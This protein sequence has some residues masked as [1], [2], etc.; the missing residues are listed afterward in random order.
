MALTATL[1][2][3]PLPDIITYDW[4]I[5]HDACPDAEIFKE[6]YPEGTKLT[7]EVVDKL[8]EEK[9]DLDFLIGAAYLI[10]EEGLQERLHKKTSRA[11]KNYEETT[12]SVAALYDNARKAFIRER[13]AALYEITQNE[14]L[15]TQDGE[16]YR[17]D[18]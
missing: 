8:L 14:D 1:K 2:Q 18:F 6:L 17:L 5:K 3:E 9:V 4:L 11:F 7:D 10:Y 16:Q 15:P 13:I 12:D